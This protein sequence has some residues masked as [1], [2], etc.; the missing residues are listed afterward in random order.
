M[1]DLRQIPFLHRLPMTRV[2]LW[3]TRGLYHAVKIFLRNDHRR[4]RCE[5]IWYEVDLSKGLELSL[6]LFGNFQGHVLKAG[7]FHV[8]TGAVIFGIG[9]NIGSMALQFA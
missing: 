3:V 6:F 8:P 4:I 5:G 7:L 1:D 2:K 9:A